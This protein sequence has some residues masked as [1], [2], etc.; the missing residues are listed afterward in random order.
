M[1]F[2][3]KYRAQYREKQNRKR[4]LEFLRETCSEEMLHSPLFEDFID[5]MKSDEVTSDG[6]SGE[7]DV[8]YNHKKAAMVV[9]ISTYG[10]TPADGEQ[11]KDIDKIV[12]EMS[13]GVDSV[14]LSRFIKNAM[15]LGSDPDCLMKIYSQYTLTANFNS[16]RRK[17][18]YS[19]DVEKFGNVLPLTVKNTDKMLR[20]TLVECIQMP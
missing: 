4:L 18:N 12:R 3:D 5:D 9:S 8:Q 10:P 19:F 6:G 15:F 1:S 11:L 14:R 2:I 17:K 16:M 7:E 20:D 13:I